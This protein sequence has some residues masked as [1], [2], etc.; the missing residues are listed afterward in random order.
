MLRMGERVY[1]NSSLLDSSQRRANIVLLASRVIR[2]RDPLS[3]FLFILMSNALSILIEK[4]LSRNS[5]HDLKMKPNCPRLFHCLFVD[6][7]VIFGKASREEPEAIMRII[8]EYKS[9]TGQEVNLE[10]FP[11]FFTKNTSADLRQI[12]TSHLNF[13]SAISYDSYLGVP[14]D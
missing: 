10:K 11:V 12:I 7:T 5:I 2:H 3:L 9:L 13:P 8:N 14:T 6:D 4:G 1:P